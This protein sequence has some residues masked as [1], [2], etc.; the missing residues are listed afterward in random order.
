MEGIDKGF[1]KGTVDVS[2]VRS[3]GGVLW[4]IMRETYYQQSYETPLSYVKSQP[5]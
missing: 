1:M 2:S 4:S 5:A 3:C